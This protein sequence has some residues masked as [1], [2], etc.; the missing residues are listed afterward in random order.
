M[1]KK[2]SERANY[3]KQYTKEYTRRISL[4]LSLEKDKDIIEAIEKKD[5]GNLQNG[6]RLLIREAIGNK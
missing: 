2:A 1:R 4:C 3:Q 6:V 5:S